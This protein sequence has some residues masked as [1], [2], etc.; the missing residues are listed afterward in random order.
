MAM[1]ALHS[2]PFHLLHLTLALHAMYI[3]DPVEGEDDN[4]E[5]IQVILSRTWEVKHVQVIC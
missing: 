1:L 3:I 2:P 5:A 4:D